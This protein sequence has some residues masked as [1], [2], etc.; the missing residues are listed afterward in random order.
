MAVVFIVVLF[1]IKNKTIFKN[2][3]N[4]ALNTQGINQT[5]GLVYDFN[6]E[7]LG[8]LVNRDTD[9]DG[10]LDWEESL[11]GTNPNKKDSNDDGT[12]DSA[13]IEKLKSQADQ[14]GNFDLSSQNSGNLTETDKFSR[15]F[16]STVAT[17]NQAGPMD[18]ETI[19]KLG[20]SL[21]ERI[22][23]STP[24]KV[25]TLSDLKIINDNSVGAVKKY[26]AGWDGIRKKYPVSGSVMDVL[27]KFII[28]ETDVDVSALKELDPI[29]TQTNKIIDALIKM[30]V[31][32][33]LSGSHLNVIN[34]IEVLVENTSDI[35][36]YETD[37]I[38]ALSAI[39]QYEQNTAI[40][41]TAIDDLG[42]AIA[43]KLNN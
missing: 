17:L 41:E 2:T 20:I 14:N 18:Q 19:D 16:F 6:N 1:F 30:E 37:V 35:K 22:Q 28:N 23:N 38:I 40:L 29:I 9:L 33:S 24:K 31:P 12:P 7:K 5:D 4:S 26:N 3:P 32:Q 21:A 34:A 10:V 8:N 13:E 27:K 25:Y 11:W 15:E 43:Q 42:N 39:S 36:L